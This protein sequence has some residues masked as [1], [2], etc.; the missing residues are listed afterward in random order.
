MDEK[1]TMEKMEMWSLVEWLESNRTVKDYL[2]YC[3][4]DISGKELLNIMNDMEKEKYYHIIYIM[5]VAS[6]GNMEIGNALN[7]VATQM[8][9]D[10]WKK[11]GTESVYEE[12]KRVLKEEIIKQKDKKSDDN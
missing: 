7:K 3:L 2:E 11:R 8:I 12:F 9:I 1:M 10:E 4:S 6:H 5:V